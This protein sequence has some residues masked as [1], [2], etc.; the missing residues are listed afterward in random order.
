AP[1]TA[2]RACLAGTGETENFSS[3]DTLFCSLCESVRGHELEEQYRQESACGLASGAPLGEPLT[4][5]S[6]ARVHPPDDPPPGVPAAATAPR[7]SSAQIAREFLRISLLGFGG[8]SAHLA[9]MLEAVVE[10]RRWI[11]REHFLHLVALTHLLPGPNSSEVAIHIGYTQRGWRGALA[12]GGAF[13]GPTFFLMLAL[14][15]LYFRFG[16]L[17][18]IQ[19]LFWGLKPVIIAA[20]VGAG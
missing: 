16:T 8:P 20:I 10:R 13:L 4:A 9:V 15:A 14:A 7:P 11:D 17:P 18:A 19:P 12:A 5:H 1:T 3:A 6:M 2:R